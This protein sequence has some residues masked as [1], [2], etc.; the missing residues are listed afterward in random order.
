M[1]RGFVFAKVLL[2][3]FPREFDGDELVLLVGISMSCQR[4][5][6]V[7]I[8]GGCSFR[9]FSA[10]SVG[11]DDAAAEDVEADGKG[12]WL[13]TGRPVEWS[14]RELEVV[15]G[16]IDAQRRDI[17]VQVFGVRGDGLPVR[18]GQRWYGWGVAWVQSDAAY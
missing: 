3:K 2:Q 6:A 4:V 11:I 1:K 14:F 17:S 9:K 15:P 13:K 7:A 8:E 5:G 18:C 10:S 12:V 16:K